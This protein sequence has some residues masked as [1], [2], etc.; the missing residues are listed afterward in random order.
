VELD[1]LAQLKA[2]FCACGSSV[3]ESPERA[4][5]RVWADAMLDTSMTA[6]TATISLLVRDF[7]IASNL[8]YCLDCIF[9]CQASSIKRWL[10][11]KFN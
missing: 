9:L 1:A 3:S 7:M 4:Q 10:T 5:R 11:P 2:P 6:A 8:G